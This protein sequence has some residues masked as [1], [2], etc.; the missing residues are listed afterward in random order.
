[1]I[2]NDMSI[3]NRITE[4]AEEVSGREFSSAESHPQ[5]TLSKRVW[6]PWVVDPAAAEHICA[7]LTDLHKY[8]LYNYWERPGVTTSEGFYNALLKNDCNGPTN[9]FPIC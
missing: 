8:T 3:D 7:D 1:M 5:R 4:Y 9:L 6:T 2:R